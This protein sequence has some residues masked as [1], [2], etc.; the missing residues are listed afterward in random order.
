MVGVVAVVGWVDGV[1]RLVAWP[2]AR[3]GVCG[4]GVGGWVA[5]C[6]G[7]AGGPPGGG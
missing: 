7:S 6:V 1:V 2:R 5:G 3:G 4:W